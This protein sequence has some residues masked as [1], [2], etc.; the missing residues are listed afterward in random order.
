MVNS[1]SSV[2]GRSL[3][4]DTVTPDHLKKRVDIFRKDCND[5][6]QVIGSVSKVV[7]ETYIAA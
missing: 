2:Y 6:T 7:A 1:E 3:R 5:G 4:F